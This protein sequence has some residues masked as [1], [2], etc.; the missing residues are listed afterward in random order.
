MTIIDVYPLSPLQSGILYHSLREES[1]SVY[2]LQF[3]YS[4]NGHLSADL[5]EDESNE[6][7]RRH[8]ILRTAFNYDD[9]KKPVQLVLGERTVEFH[10][11]DLSG[12]TAAEQQQ[13]IRQFR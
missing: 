1:A 6:L 13:A 2:L 9:L 4:L 7:F 8:D 11:E 5:V 3:S 10:R 12:L